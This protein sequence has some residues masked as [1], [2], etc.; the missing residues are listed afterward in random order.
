MDQCVALG[1]RSITGSDVENY[2]R[3]RSSAD[4]V[5]E[6]VR[7]TYLTERSGTATNCHGDLPRFK[8]RLD[9]YAT[10]SQEKEFSKSAY[11]PDFRDCSIS[12]E[13]R[14]RDLIGIWQVAGSGEAE[15][16]IL[17]GSF[18]VAIPC[19]KHPYHSQFPTEPRRQLCK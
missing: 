19:L 17:A 2:A 15:E 7:G 12:R 16:I 18:T 9:S 3:L 14:S 11:R 8:Y 6:Q 10:Q 13:H 1:T 4:V 5:I